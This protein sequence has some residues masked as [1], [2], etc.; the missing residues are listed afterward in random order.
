MQRKKVN[1]TEN[2]KTA[3]KRDNKKAT[4]KAKD[5]TPKVTVS[6]DIITVTIKFKP[7][8]NGGHN[9]VIV[10]NID[11]NHVSVGLTTKPKK[12]K[13]AT[14]YKLEQ[15][16]LSDGKTSYMRRQGVVAPKKTYGKERSGIMTKKDYAR[17]GEYG[18]KAKQ[19]Y[20]EEKGKKK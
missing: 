1:K 12:G 2:K 3:P 9:H 5:L 20:I 14:N 15:S 6:D 4:N 13:N 17:A 16:P 7:D 18:E 10:D 11:E 8:K 19:K